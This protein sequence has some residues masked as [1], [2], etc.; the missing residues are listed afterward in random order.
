MDKPEDLLP[1]SELVSLSVEL[2]S[3]YVSNNS[4]PAADLPKLLTEIH[5]ALR[6]MNSNG[7][8]PVLPEAKQAPAV[9]VKKSVTPDFIVCL[10]DGKSFKS[11]RRHLQTKYGLTPQQYRE[12]WN[13][14]S[15]YPMVAPNYAAARSALARAAGL[16]HSRSSPAQL[17][18]NQAKKQIAFPMAI[19][20]GDETA[21]K[22]R[23]GHQAKAATSLPAVTSDVAI[24]AAP[25]ANIGTPNEHGTPTK[26]RRGRPAK[27]LDPAPVT[28]GEPAKSSADATATAPATMHNGSPKRRGGR[29]S[30][31]AN[32]APPVA[33]EVAAASASKSSRSTGKTKA[34][35][36]SRRPPA[37]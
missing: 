18:P 29:Q 8:E 4:V 31:A 2:A 11:L 23:R 21:R 13:L 3:A 12:K 30:K 33:S 9:S 28:A 27:A 1:A 35:R 16:G 34:K 17:E 22:G 37:K 19:S 6:G 10:E 20:P 26:R 15:D 14:P 24:D 7:P 5:S 36:A 32:S 25:E